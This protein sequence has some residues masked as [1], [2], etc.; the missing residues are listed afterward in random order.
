MKM[1]VA[2]MQEARVKRAMERA[3]APVFKKQGK[4]E[5]FRSRLRQ[6]QKRQTVSLK[7]DEDAE[8]EDYLAST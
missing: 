1:E 7:T 4:Q 5:M 2:G 3:A 6:H 8:L